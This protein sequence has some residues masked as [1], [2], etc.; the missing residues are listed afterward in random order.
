MPEQEN[1]FFYFILDKCCTC[2]CLPLFGCCLTTEYFCRTYCCCCKP[3]ETYN[4]Q[5]SSS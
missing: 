3:I 1:S 5:T 4:E 2:T